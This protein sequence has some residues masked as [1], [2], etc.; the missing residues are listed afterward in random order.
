MK[1]TFLFF[2]FLSTLKCQDFNAPQLQTNHTQQ[3]II[4][5]STLNTNPQPQLKLN[6]QARIEFYKKFKNQKTTKNNNAYK[7]K[8]Q[9]KQRPTHITSAFSKP[10]KETLKNIEIIHETY[11]K[12][13]PLNPFTAIHKELNKKLPDPTNKNLNL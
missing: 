6:N 8:K 13:L 9:N 11:L 1:Y 10:S 4:K 5:F 12:V 3:P 2:T 7:P